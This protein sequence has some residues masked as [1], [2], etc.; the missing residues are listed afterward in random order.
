MKYFVIGLSA[1]LLS[2]CGV[3]EYTEADKKL[4]ERLSGKTLEAELATVTIN[5]DGT[6][7]GLAG[8]KRDIEL[9]GTWEIK[10]GYYCR[11]L[12]QRLKGV[13]VNQCQIVEFLTDNKVSFDGTKAD[14]RKPVIYSMK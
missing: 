2:S 9:S 1:A 11:K 5:S 7:D 4:Q 6:F 14:G 10:N 8:T 12:E 3:Y 13:P